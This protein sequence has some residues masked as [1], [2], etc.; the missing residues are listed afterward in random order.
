MS[1]VYYRAT[2]SRTAPP[3][4]KVTRATDGKK[5][6]DVSELSLHHIHGY[7]GFDARNNL[8]YVNS[9]DSVIY[10]AAGAGIVHNITTGGYNNNWSSLRLTYAPLLLYYCIFV[11]LYYCIIIGGIILAMR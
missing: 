7:R 5:K 10:H 4:T 3:Q 8:H 2:V 1:F 9:G 11:F 6:R